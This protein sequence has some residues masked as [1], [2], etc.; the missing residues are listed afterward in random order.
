MLTLV[1]DTSTER[2]L[3]AIL[4]G[5]KLLFRHDLPFGLNNSKHLLPA[6]AESLKQTQLQLRQFALIAVG[7]GPGSYTGIRVGAMVAKSFAYASEVPLVG[8][9]SLEGFV[10][11]GSGEFT[12]LI[13]ARIGGAYLLKGTKIGGQIVHQA[14]PIVCPLD[15]VHLHTDEQTIMVTPNRERLQPLLQAMY[16]SVQWRWQE[17]GP[18]PIQLASSAIRKFQAGLVSR[19]GQLE[20]MYLRKTQ[21]EI[22]KGLGRL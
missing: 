18:C 17:C 19:N 21:A 2:G 10:P 4:D 5:T 22:E 15:Q 6:I 14:Q 9:C 3:V 12:A 8:V 1:I 16:P 13:D 11:E 20:L 7:I